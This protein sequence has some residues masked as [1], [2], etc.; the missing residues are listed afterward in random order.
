MKEKFRVA[1]WGHQS[2]GH[3][4]NMSDMCACVRIHTFIHVQIYCGSK[5]VLKFCAFWLQLETSLVD[6]PLVCKGEPPA[7][8]SNTLVC[9]L[10]TPGLPSPHPCNVLE[11]GKHTPACGHCSAPKRPQMRCEKTT[12]RFLTQLHL[13][14]FF[15][16]AHSDSCGALKCNSTCHRSVSLHI[17]LHASF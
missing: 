14:F 1:W 15:S 5:H 3:R 13:R 11:G 2:Q 6:G 12:H 17:G 8:G 9:S 10:P 7:A 4:D 16:Y